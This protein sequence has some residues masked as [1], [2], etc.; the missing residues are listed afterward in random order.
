MKNFVVKSASFATPT[1]TPTYTIDDL[2][3]IGIVETGDERV[4][5]TDGDTFQTLGYVENVRT[6]IEI[7]TTAVHYASGANQLKQGDAGKLTVVYQQKAKGKGAE[8]GTV[9]VQ[10]VIGANAGKD[11][12]V[13]NI[14]KNVR[15]EGDSTHALSFRAISADGVTSPRAITLVA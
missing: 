3:S 15:H 1:G 13:A 11:C 6:E 2:Q 5:G 10:C 12:I 7:Q 4:R 9:N 8:S 14:R